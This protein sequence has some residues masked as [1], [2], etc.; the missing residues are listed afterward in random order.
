MTDGGMKNQTIKITSLTAG[1]ALVTIRGGGKR[2]KAR[3][4]QNIEK[5]IEFVLPLGDRRTDFYLNGYHC[6]LN[7]W[8]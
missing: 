2:L 4:F 6:V 3:R 5:A 7:G 8:L 1:T